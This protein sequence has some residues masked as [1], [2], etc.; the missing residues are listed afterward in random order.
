M[1]KPKKCLVMG[2]E[3][4]SPM[5]MD[6]GEME[7]EVMDEEEEEMDKE[8]AMDGESPTGATGLLGIDEKILTAV[9]EEVS[10]KTKPQ[11]AQLEGESESPPMLSAK[12]VSHVQSK[13]VASHMQVKAASPA[14]SKSAAT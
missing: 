5:S 1:I 8:V 11:M 12:A 7:E 9:L 2:T 10:E 4:D 14:Q 3:K 6:G 13:A